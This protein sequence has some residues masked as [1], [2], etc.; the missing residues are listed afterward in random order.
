MSDNSVSWSLIGKPFHKTLR[1]R[2]KKK[3]KRL[4][5]PKMPE[6]H[7]DIKQPEEDFHWFKK[8]IDT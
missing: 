6:E 8:Q 5:N 3:K 4:P 7:T 2:K 1:T